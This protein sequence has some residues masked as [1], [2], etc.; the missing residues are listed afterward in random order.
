MIPSG[1]APAVVVF[2]FD[3]VGVVLGFAV[4]WQ[5]AAVAA[6]I[7]ATLLLAGA[8]AVVAERRRTARMMRDPDRAP[9][10]AE[11]A[12]AAEETLRASVAASHEPDVPAAGPEPAM[13][14]IGPEAAVHVTE[15]G[16]AAM[17]AQAPERAVAPPDDRPW[18]VGLRADDLLFIV[19]GGIAGAVVAG[20]LG[21]VLLYLDFYRDHQDAILDASVGGLT[22]A[23]GV[24]GGVVAGMAMAAVLG[25]PV[26]RWLGVAIVPFLLALG[27]GKLAMVL[28][29]AGQGLPS[30]ASWAT[31]YAGP[32]PWG[33]L[34]PLIPSHPA[35]VYEALTSAGALLVVLLLA[36]VPAFRRHPAALFA[37]GIGLWAAGRFAVAF[38]WRDPLLVGDLN[39][40]QIVTAGIVAVALVW[41]L[42]IVVS[43]R[44]GR[45]AAGTD[46]QGTANVVVETGG[47]STADGLPRPEAPGPRP[48][49]VTS[50]TGEESAT[51]GR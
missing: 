25:A 10:V 22:L 43:A 33:S 40:D 7:F 13:P 27:L 50:G 47:S 12:R 42:G 17:T 9:A 28:G 39:G 29:G 36:L 49:E 6:V 4:R 24:V 3:P 34:A 15:A 44:R 38:T 16:P 45:P 41:L 1:V 19:A 35:Q 11:A 5:I 51:A 14:A 26:A 31:A 23:G 2:D 32:G 46:D 8:L 37:V 20:R 30:D 21:W 48:A 18:P